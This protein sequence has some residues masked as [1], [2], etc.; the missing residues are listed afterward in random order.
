[1]RGIYTIMAWLLS[2]K[3][4]RGNSSHWAKDP[5]CFV[6]THTRAGHDLAALLHLC[7]GGAGEALA[8]A[9]SEGQEPAYDNWQDTSYGKVSS[10]S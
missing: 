2:H 9:H 6:L 10:P 5:Q 3:A 7:P 1:M 8:T 4:V